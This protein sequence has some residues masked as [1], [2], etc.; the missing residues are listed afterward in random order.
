M[1]PS[2]LTVEAWPVTDP[3]QAD[4]NQDTVL[5][6]EPTDPDQR[7]YSGSLYVVADG[8]GAGSRGQVASRY[9][10]QRIMHHYFTHLE[11]DLG[12]RLREAVEAANAD[13][14]A[15]AHQQ[16]ELVKVGATLVAAAL[17]GEEAHIAAVG[18]SRA[19]L[20]REG[21]IQ[22]I[23]RDHTLV[24]QLLDEEAISPEEAAEHP[25]R[26]VVLRAL[27]SEE[28]VRVDIFD[29]RLRPDDSLVLCSDGLSRYLH[30]DE[31][32]GLISASSPRSAAETLVR[33]TLDRGGKENVSVIAMLMR[34]GA[35]ALTADTPHTWDGQPASFEMQPTLAVRRTDAPPPAP[36]LPPALSA[37]E[38]I[39]HGVDM[40]QYLGD[41]GP[42][43]T[44]LPPDIPE[45]PT[46]AGDTL[47][48]QAAPAYAPQPPPVPPAYQPPAAPPAQPTPAYGMEAEAPY[49]PQAP[50]YPP[51]P[52]YAPPPAYG[53]R[54]VPRGYA[55]PG[56]PAYTPPPGYAIDPVTGLPPVPAGGQVG[57]G[58]PQPTPPYGPRIYQPASPPRP[59]RGI[60]LG[61]FLLA[62][63]IAVV[64]T[65]L[66][67]VILIN[68][69]N[70]RLPSLGGSGA[71]AATTPA[72]PQSAATPTGPAA[73]LP[74]TLPPTQPAL[75]TP[76]SIP[77][78][79]PGMALVDGGPFQR[80]V[81]DE[82]AQAAILSCINES[83]VE[84]DPAC[85]PDY[86]GD[87]QPVE[88]VTL[89]PFY[90]DVT[91][92]TNLDY[93]ACVAAEVCTPPSN[94]EFY[95]D[96]AFG[97]HPVVYVNH[98][99]ALQY[100]QWA[101]KRLPTEAEWEKAAGWDDLKKEQRVYPWG[102]RFDPARCNSEESGIGDTTPVG[103]YSPQ[104]DSFYGVADMAGNVWEWCADWYDEGYYKK[105]PKENPQGP[106]SGSYRV[107]RGGSWYHLEYGVRASYRHWNV[108]GDW[109]YYVGFRC[110]RRAASP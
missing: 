6:H 37:S 103:K 34:D 44:S 66:M 67:V 23:T 39:P 42:V 19:Y 27:G 70:W 3:G 97:Q 86:F 109:H 69:L 29:L 65:A 98:S 10:A 61:R 59:R 20:I 58:Y 88:Q 16:P 76:T 53:Q 105:S 12:L 68:P 11:P 91:E 14:Y 82:E 52:P 62:G 106:A 31:I 93:A 57:Y 32:A 80:G 108:P 101:G 87:A 48:T 74:T 41:S 25:R 7:R 77:T 60:P 43:G 4:E 78:T 5:I 100:C 36:P 38:T 51:Q 50:A 56:Q 9:A 104:G 33:K 107:L 89:S 72:P 8:T 75:P 79:P 81:T 49:P 35:P 24:Q 90:I 54:G 84:G 30:A 47:R 2:R 83:T 28:S 73:G 15:Y 99:Q 17:R 95:A 96:A 102:D 55:P 85:L 64:L 26:D 40:R 110:S 22:Q 63:L 21:A 71:S 1:S 46:Q 92:V 18:D 45:P 13:L 94:D